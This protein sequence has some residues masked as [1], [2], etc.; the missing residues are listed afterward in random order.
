MAAGP[1]ASLAETNIAQAGERIADVATTFAL[2][3]EFRGLRL[4]QAG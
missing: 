1:E 2:I 3:P 4:D